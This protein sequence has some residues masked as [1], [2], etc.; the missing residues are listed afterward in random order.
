MAQVQERTTSKTSDRLKVILLVANDGATMRRLAHVLSQDLHFHM[1]V[2]SS[3][4]AAVKFVRHIIPHL[5]IVDDCLP[6]MTGIQLYDY[7]HA[8][9]GLAKTRKNS[10]SSP[11]S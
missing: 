8:Y 6:D 5:L 9:R 4:F 3:G 1:F 11:L 7:L 10:S 2:A